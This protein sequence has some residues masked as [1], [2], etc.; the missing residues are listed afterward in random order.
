MKSKYLTLVRDISTGANITTSV[1]FPYMG[2]DYNCDELVPLYEKF[3]FNKRA[4]K[5]CIGDI[6]EFTL[7]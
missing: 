5:V 2:P 3:L 1:V 6:N 7:G 4:Q